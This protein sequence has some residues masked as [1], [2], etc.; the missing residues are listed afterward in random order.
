MIEANIKLCV[1]LKP[2]D[3]SLLQNFI[4]WYAVIYT[5]VLSV[6]VGQAWKKYN[7]IN[8]EIDREADALVLLVQTG[9]MFQDE[10]FSPALFF[11]VKRYVACVTLLQANDHRVEGESHE[12]MKAVRKCVELLIQSHNAE[13]SLKSEL[14]HQFN[15]AFD[16]RGDRFDLLEQK[17]P[18][19]VWIIF[20]LASLLWLWGFFW[21]EFDSIIFKF[22]VLGASV[23]SISYLFY[24]A[25]D[26]DDPAKGAWKMEFTSFENHVF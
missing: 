6:V 11:A 2:G 4:E 21:L 14:L 7:D 1:P 22:Y 10:I 5:L 15:E 24:L 17:L 16:A 19:H 18:N 20:V 26:L 12:K 3:Q 8:S 23:L 9:R 13:D 25:R